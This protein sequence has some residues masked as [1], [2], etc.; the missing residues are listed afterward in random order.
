M[1]PRQEVP[2]DL[3]RLAEIQGL[4]VSREQA[5]GCGLSRHVIQRLVGASQWVPLARGIYLTVPIVPS[6]DSLAWAGVLLGGPESRL[7]PVSSGHL[8]QL[9][10]DP[11]DPID[12][13]VPLRRLVRVDGPWRFVRERP[14]VRSTRSIG[15]PP[16]LTVEDTVLDLCTVGTP[17]EV[18]GWVTTSIQKRRTTPARML[19]ALRLRRAI[20]Y[21]RLLEQVLGDAAGGVESALE[22]KYARVVERAHGLPNGRRQRSRLGLPYRTDVGY[23]PFRVLVELDGR[24]GH[25][26]TGAFRDLDRDNAH[27]IGDWLTL[28]YGWF[29]VSARPC[30]VAGQLARL[31]SHRGWTGLPSRCPSCLQVPDSDW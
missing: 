23:D 24:V 28:R 19:A 11:P 17:G 7:G 20:G 5:M 18:V 10:P 1:H 3:A 21:R 30:E 4:V 8:H 6:W 2:I 16:R 27:V 22:W 15:D 9:I 29:D 14:G 26:G 25:T 12:V 31:L 13:M